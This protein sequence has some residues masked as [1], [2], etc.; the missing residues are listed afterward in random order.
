MT[1][2]SPSQSS[3]DGFEGIAFDPRNQNVDVGFM[4]RMTRCWR[5]GMMTRGEII[6]LLAMPVRP[7]HVVLQ[8]VGN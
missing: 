6:Q 8:L 5:R 2:E 7:T 3:Q 1:Q 4:A